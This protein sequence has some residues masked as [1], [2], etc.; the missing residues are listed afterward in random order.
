MGPQPRLKFMLEWL[1]GSV[2]EIP[3]FGMTVV[4]FPDI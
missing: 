4:S 1:Y 2:D 3:N